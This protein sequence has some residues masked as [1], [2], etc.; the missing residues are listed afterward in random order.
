[1]RFSA[2]CF[3]ASITVHLPSPGQT[4]SVTFLSDAGDRTD[5]YVLFGH[6]Y[7]GYEVK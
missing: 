4:V 5:L 6:F 1:M 2:F 3:S 7:V